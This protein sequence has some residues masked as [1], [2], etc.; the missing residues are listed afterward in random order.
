MAREPLGTFGGAGAAPKDPRNLAT[1]QHAKRSFAAA[2][3]SACKTGRRQISRLPA[4]FPARGASFLAPWVPS[5]A[6][7][8]EPL[9]ANCFQAKVRRTPP[10]NRRKT[11]M[12]RIRAH[13]SPTH[14]APSLKVL[15]GGGFGLGLIGGAVAAPQPV[16]SPSPFWAP[17]ERDF[18][19]C[20]RRRG[21]IFIRE[22]FSNE[23][24]AGA[25]GKNR[26]G[27]GKVLLGV[28]VE[29]RHAATQSPHYS[30][31]I[32]QSA[33]VIKCQYKFHLFPNSFATI[34]GRHAYIPA[35]NKSISAMGWVPRIPI[36]NIHRGTETHPSSHNKIWIL[37]NK[38]LIKLFLTFP[39]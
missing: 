14:P 39:S 20:L 10:A 25:S 7:S 36:P 26:P 15:C 28:G 30:R 9:A 29:R 33:M 16:L 32:W 23:G 4:S 27:E 6:S 2:A 35:K 34:E 22:R 13:G 18:P 24:C 1:A 19:L 21:A 38:R 11:Q 8:P 17:T 5:A 3:H 37:G 31:Y 12:E